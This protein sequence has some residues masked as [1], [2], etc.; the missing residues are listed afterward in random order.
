MFTG[1]HAKLDVNRNPFP[2]GSW[3]FNHRENPLCSWYP[4]RGILWKVR[5]DLDYQNKELY[6]P[7]HGSTKP[8]AWCPCTT[9][10]HLPLDD[11]RENAEWIGHLYDN[12]AFLTSLKKINPSIPSDRCT[13]LL[14]RGGLDAC[15]T[16]GHRS[17][18]CRLCGLATCVPDPAR[19]HRNIMIE[20]LP[21]LNY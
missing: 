19:T 9:G 3:L 20:Q 15:Q 10:K 18:L 5:S 1:E 21:K 7:A 17:V 11:F 12:M 2:V 8:C 13:Q 4:F 6:L 16:Y 14:S